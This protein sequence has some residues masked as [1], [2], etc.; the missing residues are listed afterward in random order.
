MTSLSKSQDGDIMMMCRS[1]SQDDDIM[2]M[3]LSKSQDKHV[4]TRVTCN[5]EMRNTDLESNSV[6][7]L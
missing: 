4:F 1:K 6:L 5:Y 7:T 2:M 3:S